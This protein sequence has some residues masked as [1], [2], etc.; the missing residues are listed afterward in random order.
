MSDE[1]VAVETFDAPNDEL[2]LE[3]KKW[4]DAAEDVALVP[5]ANVRVEELAD[6][7]LRLEISYTLYEFYQRPR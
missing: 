7:K 6:G 4:R 2:A 3:M 5:D 1:W